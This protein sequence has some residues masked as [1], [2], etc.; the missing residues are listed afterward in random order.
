MNYFS[1]EE[2]QQEIESLEKHIQFMREDIL[3]QK[4]KI[5]TTVNEMSILCTEKG[6]LLAQ[7]QA[8]KEQLLKLNSGT[9]KNPDSRI[10]NKIGCYQVRLH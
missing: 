8:L 5:Q 9:S 1:T 6:E 3:K 4:T 7:K 2:I 10:S